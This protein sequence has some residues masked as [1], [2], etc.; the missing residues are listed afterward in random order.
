[1]EREQPWLA[2]FTWEMVTAQ[3]AMLCAAKNSLHKPTSGGHNVT[4]TLWENH[5]REPMNLDEAVDLCPLG[6]QRQPPNPI[7]ESSRGAMDP[8]YTNPTRSH[9]PKPNQ[10]NLSTSIPKDRPQIWIY[11]CASNPENTH[12][13]IESESPYNLSV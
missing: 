2:P 10:N 5:H 1:M 4:R 7:Q 13:G 8:A 9:H 11:L 3:N 6:C 12:L